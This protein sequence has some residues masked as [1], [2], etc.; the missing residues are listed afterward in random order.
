MQTHRSVLLSLLV[1]IA[2]VGLSSCSDDHLLAPPTESFPNDV[3][4][5]VFIRATPGSSAFRFD[6]V[7]EYVT[8][9]SKEIALVV[10][11]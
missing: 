2:G 5:G 8:I 4:G 7:R 9:A 10:T 6:V 1:F 3:S 11:P